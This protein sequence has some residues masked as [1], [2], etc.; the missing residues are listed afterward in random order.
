MTK[1]YKLLIY[2]N[3]FLTQKVEEISLDNWDDSDGDLSEIAND[4]SRYMVLLGGIGLAANQLGLKIPMIVTSSTIYT[5]DNT[6][7]LKI[8]TVIINPKITLLGE[9]T[10]TSQEGCLSFPN[11]RVSVERH[12]RISL[13]YTSLDNRRI[14]VEEISN[15]PAVVLQ[16]ELDHLNGI[17]FYDHAG[18]LKSKFLREKIR[19]FKKKNKILL[20]SI[21]L[22]R[23]KKPKDEEET[24]SASEIPSEE[25]DSGKHSEIQA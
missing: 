4:M 15:L 13:E 10:V 2:P 20:N 19:K 5:P 11:I 1:E 3:E 21:P 7:T 6:S 25:S 16:H 8:P 14:T 17:T 22:P 12:K 24:I 18:S 23:F 9:E